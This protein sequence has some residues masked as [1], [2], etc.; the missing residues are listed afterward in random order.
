LTHRRSWTG[1]KNQT[2]RKQ[3]YSQQRRT[4]KEIIAEHCWYEPLKR[5]VLSQAS[6][7]LTVKNDADEE[8]L[9]DVSEGEVLQTGYDT[10]CLLARI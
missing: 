1:R 5:E 7:V 8:Q 3:N 6:Y 4:V 10:H 2:R 9:I